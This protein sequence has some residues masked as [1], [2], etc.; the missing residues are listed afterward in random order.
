MWI[1]FI[2]CSSLMSSISE[3]CRVYLNWQSAPV[4]KAAASTRIQSLCVTPLAS[5]LLWS[6]LVVWSYLMAL[7]PLIPCRLMITYISN[8]VRLFCTAFWDTHNPLNRLFKLHRLGIPPLRIH[9]FWQIASEP[10]SFPSDACTAL[11]FPLLTCLTISLVICLLL[12]I[13]PLTH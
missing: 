6:L 13:Y 10:T 11:D 2:V 9:E 5:L 8:S 1:V 12:L 3:K 4:W 7:L